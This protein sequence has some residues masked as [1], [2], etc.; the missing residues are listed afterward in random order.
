MLQPAIPAGLKLYDK[1]AVEK[2]YKVK[3][4]HVL[5]VFALIGDKSDNVPGIN[6]VGLVTAAKYVSKGQPKP[7]MPIINTFD[8]NI[9]FCPLT[10]IF[11]KIICFSNLLNCFKSKFIFTLF[12]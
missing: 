4:E 8:L 3:A 6:S 2:K 5:D 12:L 7:P 1:A 9:F 11:F 10:P